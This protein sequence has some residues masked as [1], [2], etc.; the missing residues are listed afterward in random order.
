MSLDIVVLLVFLAVI[1]IIDYKKHIIMDELL[2]CI[3][4]FRVLYLLFLKSYID[5]LYSFGNGLLVM[6]PFLLLTL[7]M[8]KKTGKFAA[9]GCDIKLAICL[10][11]YLGPVATL[12]II[13]T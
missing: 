11:L 1:A 12:I 9:G 3:I 2:L 5:I 7:Y 10:A 6:V 13:I 4:I 8:E